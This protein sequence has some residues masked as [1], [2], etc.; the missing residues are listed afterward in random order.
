[1]QKLEIM[2]RGQ[3]TDI[4]KWWHRQHHWEV[5][6]LTCSYIPQSCSC[7]PKCLLVAFNYTVLL[8]RWGHAR[9]RRGHAAVF[10]PPCNHIVCQSH[11]LHH[12]T[13]WTSPV[14]L[15]FTFFARMEDCRNPLMY[16]EQCHNYLALNPLTD[17]KHLATLQCPL[18][19]SKRL[20]GCD[21]IGNMKE[22]N[23]KFLSAFLSEDHTD[24]FKER[25]R[26]RWFNKYSIFSSQVSQL[27]SSRVVTVYKL[28]RLGQQL[29]KDWEKQAQ[30]QQKTYLNATNQFQT[31]V[32]PSWTTLQTVLALHSPAIAVWR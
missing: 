16:L 2:V 9:M 7:K 22:F 29:E 11:H 25:V 6:R 28:V 30:L 13:P 17:K 20:V 3:F 32:T 10:N 26:I 15:Q 18:W 21:E 19:S 23:S 8:I 24:E 1:M 31:V 5:L 14:K 4:P 12:L 27:R